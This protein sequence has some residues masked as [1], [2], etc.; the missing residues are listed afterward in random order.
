MKTTLSILLATAALC[1]PA[2]AERFSSITGGKLVE[3]C[4]G[5]DKGV[6]GDCTAY[7]NGVSDAASFYQT[8]LPRDGSKGGQL[9]GYVCVPT[10]AT[11]VQLRE[12]VVAW[13]KRKPDDLG[14]QASGV[15]LNALRDTFPCQ[16]GRAG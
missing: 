6:V 8:L 4:T 5:K 12:A 3:L 7:I 14:R 9:P 2:G 11:G 16:G 10:G 1:G 15:V 13:S